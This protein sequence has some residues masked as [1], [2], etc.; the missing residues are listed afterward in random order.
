MNKAILLSGLTALSLTGFAATTL[1]QDTG[2]TTP[3]PGPAMSFADL[4][5]D[6]DGSV[7]LEEI[8]SRHGA[9]IEDRFTKADTNG[10][11]QLDADE[12]AATLE[13]QRAERRAER[14]SRRIARLVDARDANDDGVLSLEELTPKDDRGERMFSRVDKNDDGVISAEEFQ[15]MQDHMAEHKD[16]RRGPPRGDQRDDDHDRRGSDHDRR[17]DDHGPRHQDDEHRD[18]SRGDGPALWPFGGDRG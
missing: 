3:P 11:G 12:I 16:D 1:A 15:A 7:T 18:D 10:D 2:D 9:S 14:E 5:T 4:D 6:G 17:G 13:A 8:Q